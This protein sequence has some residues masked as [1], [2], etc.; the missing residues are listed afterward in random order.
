M[1]T[2]LPHPAFPNL[3]QPHPAAAVCR[4]VDNGK[5]SLISLGQGQ[6]GPAERVLDKYIAEVRWG[7]LAWPHA[8]C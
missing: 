2:V 7:W 1:L 3:P 4:T 6:E 8:V 5:L